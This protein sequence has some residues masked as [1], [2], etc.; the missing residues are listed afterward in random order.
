MKKRMYMKQAAAIGTAVVLACTVPGCGTGEISN[1]EKSTDEI[2]KTSDDELVQTLTQITGSETTGSAV[3]DKEETVYVI[4][5]SQGTPQDIIVSEWLKNI[6]GSKNLEDTTNLTDIKNVKGNESF[7]TSSNGIV[8]NTNGSDIYY[9]GKSDATLP[10]SVE[11]SY[12]LDNQKVTPE[13]LSGKSGH[14]RIRYDYINNS[15]SSIQIN[16]EPVKIYTPFVMATGLILP[17]DTFRNVTVSNGDILSEGNNMIAFGI[18]M[19]G[20]SDSL[21]LNEIDALNLD[22]DLPDYFEI[23]ADVTNFS[24][25]MAVTIASNSMVD[26]SQF[27]VNKG[28]DKLDEK[29]DA[30]TDGTAQLLDGSSQ[31]CNG[32]SSLKDGTAKLSDGVNNL[33]QGTKTYTDG[34]H[35]AK[36]GAEKLVKGSET[37]ND[38]A[39]TLSDKLGDAKNGSAQLKTGLETLNSKAP[40]LVNGISS[41][42]SGLT[43]IVDGYEGTNEKP[44]AVAGSKSVADGL[45]QL[46]Q[47]VSTLALPD[48][49][50][51]SSSL[52]AAQKSA[53]EQ[54]IKTYLNTDET[55]KA[56]LAKSTESYTANVKNILEQNGIQLDTETAAA[57]EAVM[58]GTFE[59]AFIS[60]YISAYESGMEKGM[61]EVL[62][63]VSGQLA[64]YAPQI[65]QMQGAVSQ[66][67]SGSASVA[68]GVKQLYEGTKKL[69]SG[70]DTMYE[71]AKQLP[72]GINSLYQGSTALDNGLNQLKEGAGTLQ[73]GT[74]AL[75]N[76]ISSLSNGCSE[77]DNSSNKLLSGIDQ[78]QSGVAQ[79]N[80]GA[81]QLQAGSLELKNG[82]VRFN[83]E[84]INKLKSLMEDDLKP[85]AK[86]IEAISDFNSSYKLYGG[87]NDGKKGSEKF[88]I[89]IDEIDN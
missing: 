77:L 59:Q 2:T 74:S 8:W 9:Q 62:T 33:Y 36:D 87:I 52:S 64:G 78:L 86:R 16:N 61:E 84:G 31:L 17:T 28:M 12:Y 49:S 19:P 15:N 63:E 81:V 39:K 6:N 42:Q 54:Q 22:L 68:S 69:D 43:Q 53:I 23:S 35:T 20:L 76:G 41:V 5:D 30:L 48:L 18:G 66:L 72:A 34:V 21:G 83:N 4:A 14:I 37:L 47:K 57:L 56:I 10:I 13:E 38:G 89:K 32:T 27:D 24:L 85:F 80:D 3:T 70:V 82:V 7:T 55:G 29:M 44:G 25:G 60:T 50:K 73:N 58:Q 1:T 46:N 65:T 45:K 51:Q 40:A 71:S 67:A 75:Q 79:L 11:V 26:L 88:I